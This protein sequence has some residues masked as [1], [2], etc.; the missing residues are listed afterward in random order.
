MAHGRRGEKRSHKN[1]ARLRFLW[2]ASALDLPGASLPTLVNPSLMLAVSPAA[3]LVKEEVPE[4]S[5]WF[6]GSA[7]ERQP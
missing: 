5:G 3:C 4:K 7:R 1:R 6:K 2:S